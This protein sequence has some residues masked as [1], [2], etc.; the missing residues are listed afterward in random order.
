MKPSS[1]KAKGRKFQWEVAYKVGEVLAMPVGYDEQVAP[2]EM[3]QQGVDVRLTGEAYEKFKYDVE[4]KNAETWQIPMWVNQARKNTKEGR[5]WLLC[6]RKNK[7][8]PMVILDM[9]HFFDLLKRL[10]DAESTSG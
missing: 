3:G 7:Y 5:Q 10:N 8:K 6:I 9:E 1:C 4:C 2:R